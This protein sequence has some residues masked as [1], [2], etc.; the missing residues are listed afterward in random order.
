[1]K[2]HTLIAALIVA[3]ALAV[4]TGTALAGATPLPPADQDAPACER[5]QQRLADLRT[6]LEDLGDRIAEVEERLASGELN[7][8]QTAR[9]RQQLANLEE[10]LGNVEERIDRVEAR[11]AK[12]CD[13]EP[14]DDPTD[15]PD[16]GPTE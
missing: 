7:A 10:R 12:R 4:G 3:G 1:M 16:P 15:P 11:I 14:T 8:K 9:A 5:A 13:G 6:R 2:R